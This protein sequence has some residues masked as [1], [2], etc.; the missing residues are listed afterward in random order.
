MS[1]HPETEINCKEFTNSDDVLA[2]N[3]HMYAPLSAEE[4]KRRIS[5]SRKDAHKGIDEDRSVVADMLI[6]IAFTPD[7][8]VEREPDLQ[9][10]TRKG[11]L[12]RYKTRHDT[13]KFLVEC[14]AGAIRD[15]VQQ[16]LYP[17]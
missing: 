13:N 5:L 6:R 2:K 3:V 7:V 1:S 15:I 11:K 9:M 12:L 4:T 8:C 10:K 14:G 16:L 17:W